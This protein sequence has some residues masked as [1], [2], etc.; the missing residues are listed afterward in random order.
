MEN[1]KLIYEKI[2]SAKVNCKKK[3]IV[4]NINRDSIDS[5]V[6]LNIASKFKYL[7][8]YRWLELSIVI[9]FKTLLFADKITY[10]ILDALI[11]DLFKRTKFKIRIMFETSEECIHNSGFSGTALYRTAIK[12]E[13]INKIIFIKNYEK[14]IYNDKTTYRRIISRAMLDKNETPSIIGSDVAT[15]LKMYSDDEDWVDDLEEVASELVCNV[16][17]HTEGDCLLDINFSSS[18]QDSSED[19]DKK[20]TMVNIAIINFSKYRLFDKI[21]NNLTEKTYKETDRIYSRIYGAYSNHKEM[22]D[23]YYTSDDFFLIT[24]FQNHVTSRSF[25][26]GNSGT[27]LTRLIQNIIGKAKKDYSYVL[28]GENILVFKSDYLLMSEDKF[29]GFNN[30][31]DYFNYKPESEVLNKSALFIPGT[32]YNLLL[33]KEN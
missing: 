31:K 25:K 33:I 17:S 15:I 28:S 13:Y 9:K 2:N 11:Y 3:P 6:L 21:K 7:M 23:E 8:K 16:S 10:L 30:E 26:S 20:Y 22:F 14:T 19:G 4:I 29:I 12:G 1:I 32:I 27:G 24:A 5:K 18:I